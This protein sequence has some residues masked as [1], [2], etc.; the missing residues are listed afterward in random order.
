MTN[1]PTEKARAAERGPFANQYPSTPD[2][3]Y[4]VVKGRLWRL[5]DP[6]LSP[7]RRQ[8]LV[9]QLMS[10]R[11]R[12]SGKAPDTAHVRAIRAE[13][14]AVKRSLGERG[15]PWWTDGTPDYNR[16]KVTNTPYNDWYQSLKESES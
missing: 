15:C 6:T 13:I 8:Q 14:D 11:R 9:D 12:L 2:R 1:P 10:C 3:R 5:S 4:F 16:F 7:R